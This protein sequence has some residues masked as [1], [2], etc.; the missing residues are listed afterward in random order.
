MIINMSENATRLLNEIKKTE[1]KVEL[2]WRAT[3]LKLTTF[4]A[5]RHPELQSHKSLQKLPKLIM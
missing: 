1:R 2:I 3:I 5:I 4:S